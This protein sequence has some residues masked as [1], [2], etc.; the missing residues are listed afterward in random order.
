[1]PCGH[2]VAGEPLAEA[3][4]LDVGARIRLAQGHATALQ[5]L[6][7]LQLL[8]EAQVGVGLGRQLLACQPP[9]GLCQGAGAAAAS[10]AG[11]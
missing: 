10:A 1:M 5:Q 11:T 7:L 8:D 6:V 2:A 4:D 9:V 3:D